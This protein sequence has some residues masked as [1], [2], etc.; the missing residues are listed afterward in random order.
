MSATPRIVVEPNTPRVLD[1]SQPAPDVQGADAAAAAAAAP[2]VPYWTEE[3]AQR[4]TAHA[5]KAL[6]NFYGPSM[7]ATD[8]ELDILGAPLA[9]LLEDL[10]P[11]IGSAGGQMSTTG[12]ALI[13]LG[14]FAFMALMRLPMILAVHRAAARPPAPQSEQGTEP[15]SSAPAEPGAPDV[16]PEPAGR[17]AGWQV[18]GS[19]SG[20]GVL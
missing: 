7:L 3:R 17:P 10:M 4:M 11:N 16:E 19:S 13:V 5:C 14:V 12:K 1:E 9:A 20:S 2:P 18:L 15:A 6:S 8:F